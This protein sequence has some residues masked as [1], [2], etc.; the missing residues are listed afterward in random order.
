MDYHLRDPNTKFA[1][2]LHHSVVS[3]E[4]EQLNIAIQESIMLYHQRKITQIDGTIE[5]ASISFNDTLF[6]KVYPKLNEFQKGVFVECIERDSAGLSLP[7]GSGKT[8]IAL[9]LSIYFTRENLKPVLVVA[10]KSLISSWETEIKKFFGDELEYE[11]VH[12][13]IQKKNIGLWK[14]GANTQIVLTTIDVLAGFYKEHN[15]ADKFIRQE[16]NEVGYTNFYEVPDK[17]FLNHVIGGGLFFSIEWGCLIVDEVQKYTNIDTLWCQSL[18]SICAEHR[19]LLSG[20][21]FDE[22]KVGRILGYHIIL[23]VE[24]KPRNFPETKELLTNDFK[25]LN[26]TL[27]SR[28]SNGAFIPPK[29]IEHIVTHRL[30]KEEEKVY[31]TMKNILVE[32]KNRAMIAKILDNDEEVRKLNSYKMVMIMYLRQALVCPMIPITSIAINASDVKKRNELSEIIIN[33]LDRIGISGWLNDEASV[34]S[35]RIKK[36]IQSIDKHKNERVIVFACFKSYLDVLQHYLIK[37][38]RPIFRM[39][40]SMSS[41]RRGLLIKAFEESSNGVLLLTYQLGAEGL[42]L[43]FTSTIMLVDFWWNASK[44][45]QAIGR[46]FRYGQISDEINVYFFTANTGIEKILFEKQKAKLDVLGELMTGKM[47]TKIPRLKMDKVIRLIEIADNK[48]LL[49]NVKYY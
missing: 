24:G 43:Q 15:V 30:N 16:F 21:M 19:W 26:E 48:K 5:Q 2:A 7:L 12:K 34:K 25:G 41:K 37:K 44:T 28:N 46:I 10:S 3:L 27:I 40:A 31:T 11:V 42:N 35:S 38:D 1:Y 14:I 36:N 22:P 23:N 18:G 9:L 17:P 13:S 45:Q 6:K 33:E 4:E 47:K 20:T 32:V 8:L 39:T 29:V 49:K